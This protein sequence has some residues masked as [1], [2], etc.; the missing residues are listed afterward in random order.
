[1][2]GIRPL[3]GNVFA[4]GWRIVNKSVIKLKLVLLSVPPPLQ[5][6]ARD[7]GF[8]FLKSGGEPTKVVAGDRRKVRS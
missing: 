6:A 3:L 1:M 8:S 7:S 2:S 5:F 4:T